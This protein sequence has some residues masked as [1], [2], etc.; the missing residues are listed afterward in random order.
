MVTLA[1]LLQIVKGRLGLDDNSLIAELPSAT[2]GTPTLTNDEVM[3]NILNDGANEIAR[4]VFAILTTAQYTLT[5]DSDQV[6][7]SDISDPEGRV[8]HWPQLVMIGGNKVKSCAFQPQQ[9]GIVPYLNLGVVSTAKYWWS[10]AGD[11]GFNQTLATGVVVSIRGYALPIPLDSAN[12]TT[13]TVD[14]LQ[15]IDSLTI[16]PD[17]CCWK[18]CELQSDN[19]DLMAKGP[20]YKGDYTNYKAILAHR[21][22]TNDFATAESAFPVAVALANVEGGKK[23]VLGT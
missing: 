20:I 5:Q 7:L 9:T 19:P 6:S 16:L 1:T 10:F 23:G 14:K 8:L 4:D 15:E 17:Y 22:V 21:L 18:V 13:S 12:P 11:I 2:P 3:T